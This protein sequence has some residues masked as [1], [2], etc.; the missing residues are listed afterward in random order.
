MT[1]SCFAHGQWLQKVIGILVAAAHA[2]VA[3]IVVGV[4]MESTHGKLIGSTCYCRKYPIISSAIRNTTNS[5]EGI[6]KIQCQWERKDTFEFARFSDTNL[7]ERGDRNEGQNNGSVYAEKGG[8]GMKFSEVANGQN[9]SHGSSSNQLPISTGGQTTT[10]YLHRQRFIGRKMTCRFPRPKLQKRY[11]DLFDGDGTFAHKILQLN[12][13]ALLKE[14]SNHDVQDYPRLF[15]G[16]AMAA[17]FGTGTLEISSCR[18]KSLLHLFSAT[19]ERDAH[20]LSF[21][22]L[23]HPVVAPQVH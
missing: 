19:H 21:L 12:D 3:A 9:S 2:A 22:A 18:R 6:S 4:A 7:L 5:P 11:R 1:H 20:A 15:V 14:R 8:V 13:C 10:P 17:C 23:A 16:L